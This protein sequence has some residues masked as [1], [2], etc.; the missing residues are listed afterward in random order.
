MNCSFVMG[1]T[2][3]C[4]MV[5]TSFSCTI[6]N[7]AIKLPMMVSRVTKIPHVHGL[8]LLHLQAVITTLCPMISLPGSTLRR[9]S[10]FF[11]AIPIPHALT[12]PSVPCPSSSCR[13]RKCPESTAPG[14]GLRWGCIGPN[15]PR[16]NM[17]AP[18]GRLLHFPYCYS[19]F[20]SCLCLH[21]RVQ[22][23]YGLGFAHI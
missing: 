4:S 18:S 20:H 12:W 1:E 5:P 23:Y 13:P 6:F 19:I 2:L 16:I 11:R 8:L 21:L 9:S 7:A 15:G 17:Q 14:R 10:T 3:I 22:V